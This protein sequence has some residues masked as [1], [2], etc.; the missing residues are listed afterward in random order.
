MVVVVLAV[1]GA[2]VV[3]VVVVD[4]A[5]LVV[6]AT[7][8]V[9]LA[10][11]LDCGVSSPPHATSATEATPTTAAIRTDLMTL[12]RYE[13]TTELWCHRSPACCVAAMCPRELCAD[14]QRSAGLDLDLD[15]DAGG[16]LDALQ[17]V[18]RLGVRVDDVDQPLVDAHLEVLAGVLV[19]VR[20]ADDGVAVLRRR[21]RDRSAHR[22]VGAGHRLDDLLRRLVDDLV[23]ERL[24]TDAD[25]LSHG[26]L[27]SSVGTAFGGPKFFSMSTRGLR[28]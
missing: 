7:D 16:E 11:P 10:A 1:V 3:V 19:D 5:V 6:V 26:D 14:A 13:T 9:V 8:D 4:A 17:R 12:R 24:E 28:R 25:R 2:N 21:Q 18:D 15:V 23:V 27:R 22:G 20:A